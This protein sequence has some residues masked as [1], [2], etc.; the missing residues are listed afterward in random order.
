MIKSSITAHSSVKALDPLLFV[1]FC[2]CEI[3]ASLFFSK[4]YFKYL[5][6]MHAAYKT[7]PLL[8]GSNDFA[9]IFILIYELSI[10]CL[11]TTLVL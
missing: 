4:L 1:H 6:A 8:V 9:K 7:A 10:F 3:K 11:R 5:Y 2:C